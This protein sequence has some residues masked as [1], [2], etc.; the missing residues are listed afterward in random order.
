MVVTLAEIRGFFSSDIAR[1]IVGKTPD[2]DGK[3]PHTR[4]AEIQ[5]YLRSSEK[6]NA[7]WIAVDD[8]P[9]LFPTDAPLL[10]TESR[11]GFNGECALRLRQMILTRRNDA[12][13]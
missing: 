3:K 4:F 9:E 6:L 12:E 1:R 5:E 10:L 13:P 8:S 2:F 7:S 11:L